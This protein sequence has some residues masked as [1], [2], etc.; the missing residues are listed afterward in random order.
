MRHLGPGQT[1]HRAEKRPASSPGL[2]PSSTSSSAATRA[3]SSG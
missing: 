2:L 1:E 3:T